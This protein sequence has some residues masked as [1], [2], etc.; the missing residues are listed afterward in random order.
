MEG[1]SEY[2]GR[3]WR[4]RAALAAAL[5]AAPLAASE[6]GEAPS[7]AERAKSV[8]LGLLAGRDFAPEAGCAPVAPCAAL[9]ARLRAGDFAVVEPVERSDRPDLPSYLRARKQCPGLDPARVTAGHRIFAATRNFAAYRLEPQPHGR[10]GDEILVFRAQ[11]YV[12]LDGRRGAAASADGPE[13]LLPGTFMAVS[14]RGCRLL[15][16]ARAEDGDW[17]AKHNVV[18]DGDHASELLRLDGRYVVLNLTPIAAPR[19]PKANWWYA[20]ELWD[21][22]AHAD[23]DLRQQR[24]VYSFGY[25]PA[26]PLGVSRA[27]APSSPG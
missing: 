18:D 10:G 16:A 7:Y 11:H 17:F 8:I 2:R 12:L 22:G 3:R 9:L 5:V 24:R 13:T 26:P 1:P 19:Q 20:L 21:L 15:A 4:L 27:A 6:A 14:V 23:A 25:K